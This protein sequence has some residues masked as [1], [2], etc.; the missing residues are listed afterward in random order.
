MLASRV[1]HKG[2]LNAAL[3]GNLNE[4]IDGF[5]QERSVQPRLS[6]KK[7]G[8]LRRVSLSKL[9]RSRIYIIPS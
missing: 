6:D 4:F 3:A 7:R 8:Y 5:I 1:I 9:I 2:D